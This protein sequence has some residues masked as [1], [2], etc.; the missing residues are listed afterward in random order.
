MAHMHGDAGRWNTRSRWAD[1]EHPRL[2][3]LVD[4]AGGDGLAGG[5]VGWLVGSYVVGR[6]HVFACS[7]S[8]AAGRAGGRVRK[9]S[10]GYLSKD[11]CG[12]S[13]SYGE[14]AS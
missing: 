9:A 10:R 2:G 7:A 1:L 13:I 3:R 12:V 5:P 14:V 6:A 8:L 11:A 4:R